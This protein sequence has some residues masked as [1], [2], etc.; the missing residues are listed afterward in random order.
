MQSVLLPEGRAGGGRG[1]PPHPRVREVAP[2]GG[3]AEERGQGQGQG[4]DG[5]DT[6]SETSTE[7]D[8][9]GG[10]VGGRWGPWQ[11]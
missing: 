6:Q 3:E 9:V 8:E 5:E 2:G 7:V 1:L 4:G 11:G 10:W